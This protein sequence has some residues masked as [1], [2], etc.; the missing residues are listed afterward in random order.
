MKENR[1]IFKNLD[2][3]RKGSDDEGL[4]LPVEGG[5]V[6][7]ARD[8]LDRRKKTLGALKREEE[9]LERELGRTG[10]SNPEDLIPEK[11]ELDK[12]EVKMGNR[13]SLAKP[14]VGESDET[15]LGRTG[16]GN[17]EDLIP[18]KKELDKT[19]VKRGNRGSLSPGSELE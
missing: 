12:T 9:E 2:E 7:E 19:E 3:P 4:E 5:G 14:K 1:L 17:P 13:G 11:K 15:K 6:P 16:G 18:E 10:G 8:Q